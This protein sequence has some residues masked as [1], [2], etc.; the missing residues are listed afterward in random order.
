MDPV[1]PRRTLVVANR[2]ATT[3]LLLQE[4]DRHAAE[5]PTAFTLLIPDVTS[6][7]AADWTLESALKVLRGAARGPDGLRP[8]R[9]EGLMGGPDPFESIRRALADG[10][11]D[12]V[13]ISTLPAP[14]SEW[15]RRDL[16]RRVTRLKVPVT[17]ITQ[18]EGEPSGIGAF[19]VVG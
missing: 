10:M 19:Q 16:P 6:R 2:T 4:I 5:R 8:A 1:G 11:Y 9:V 15:L 17:V 12:D 3:P 18:P 14:T 7:K 13:I